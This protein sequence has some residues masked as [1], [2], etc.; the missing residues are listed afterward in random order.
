[1]DATTDLYALGLIVYE[2][3]TG[4]AA[5]SGQLSDILT[6]Q[7]TKPP[8]SLLRHPELDAAPRELDALIAKLLA[9][10]SDE[11]PSSASAVRDAFLE[12]AYGSSGTLARASMATGSTA[13]TPLPP[14]TDAAASEAAP[15][16]APSLLLAFGAG[17]LSMVLLAGGGLA[18]HRATTADDVELDTAEVPAALSPEMTR[19]FDA[20]A[21]ADRRAAAAAILAFEPRDGVPAW[22]DAAAQLQA[23]RSCD[24][25]AA[26]LAHIQTLGDRRARPTVERMHNAPTRGCGRRG[27][28]DCYAC[29]REELAATLN[30]LNERE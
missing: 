3:L 18:I 21:L 14:L 9:A 20:P 29:V 22:L 13:G 15:R 30:T 4:E 11:R 27:R 16:R 26:A 7:L 5:Y 19:L 28:S 2:C 1:M 17:V 6:E 23:A 25:R 10:K 12:L 8:P 24:D